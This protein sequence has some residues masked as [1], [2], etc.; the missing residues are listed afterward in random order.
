MAKTQIADVIVPELFAPYVIQHT[1]DTSALVGSGIAQSSALLD[2][3]VAKGGKV[4]NLPSFNELSGNDEV[5]SDSASL[6]PA[7]VEAYNTAAPILIRGKAWSANELAGALAGSDPMT[8]AGAMIA[9]WWNIQE[10]RVLTSILSGIF[11]DAIKTTHSNDISGATGA[12][13]VISANAV[14]DTKQLLGD[15]ANNLTAIAMHSAVY[16]ALQKQNL[17]EYIPNSQGVVDFPTY[18]GYKVIVDDGIL[19]TGAIY[20]TYL[21]AAGAFARGEG[22]PDSL[23]PIEMGRDI[24]ASDD[25]LVSRRALCLNPLG[26]SWKNP[27][28]ANATPDNTELANGANWT[29]TG[30]D[31]SIGIAMLKHKIG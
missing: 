16:T 9:Q 15:A 11:A 19:P 21:F 8:A 13:A 7:K 17:I 25:I 28:S 27:A 3:L 14:L 22:V 29:K 12:A 2:E 23:T 20:S 1:K 10:R 31:K 26:I 4:I 30:S 18:L 5:L 24:L 6:V